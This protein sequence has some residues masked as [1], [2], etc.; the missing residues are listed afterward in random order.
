VASK[1]PS[2]EKA[3]TSKNDE[4]LTILQYLQKKA[5][6]SNTCSFPVLKTSKTCK[7]FEIWSKLQEKR[8]AQGC[9]KTSRND[10][11]FEIWP[12]CGRRRPGAVG[13]VER[14]S[15]AHAKPL[16]SCPAKKPLSP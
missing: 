7:N 15:I 5:K 3:K 2:P 6:T 11:N 1:S 10:D 8:P 16:S 9:A 4:K 12:F 13:A 14:L